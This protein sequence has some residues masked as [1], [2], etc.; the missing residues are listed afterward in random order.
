MVDFHRAF[1][2]EIARS[3]R[4]HDVDPAILNAPLPPLP[5]ANGARDHLQVP[6]RSARHSVL[7][8]GSSS[9]YVLPAL[10][11]G[12]S[13]SPTPSLSAVPASPP[14]LRNGSAPGTAVSSPRHSVVSSRAA[15]V[16]PSTTTPPTVSVPPSL[17]TRALSIVGSIS[18]SGKSRDSISVIS[19][20]T[21]EGIPVTQNG[22]EDT[23]AAAKVSLAVPVDNEESGV[24]RGGSVGRKGLKRLSTLM[25]K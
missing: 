11:L 19:E 8:Q 18:G 21:A 23:I 22:A 9:S 2:D 12:P 3:P 14:D 4:D 5:M 7:S 15:R 16:S 24:S 10:R 20:G 6:S 1:A 25:R 13:P 17:S